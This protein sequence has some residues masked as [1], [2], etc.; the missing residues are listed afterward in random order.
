LAAVG[1]FTRALESVRTAGNHLPHHKALEARIKLLEASYE[2]AT[3]AR[4]KLQGALAQQNWPEVLRIADSFLELAPECRE[5]KQARD[6]AMRRLG[7]RVPQTTYVA[8]TND[9]GDG[10]R[11]RRLRDG[12][13]T[14][15]RFILWVDGVGGFLV[16]TGNVVTLG[17]ATPA[18][19]VEIPILGDLSRQHATIVR[20]GEGYVIRSDRELQVNGRVTG[21]VA[22]RDGDIVRLG[23]TVDLKFSTPCPVSGTARL[24]LVSRHRL[25]LSLAGILLMADNCVIGP[26]RQTHVQ[27]PVGSSQIVIYRQGEGLF[28]RGAGSLEIDGQSHDGR[29]SLRWTSRVIAGDVSLSL[30]P[31]G[32]PLSHV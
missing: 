21:Q 25:H 31:V 23:R 32:S 4:G 29:G 3:A 30:E 9:A 16:C 13:G 12:A 26:T 18:T 7:V 5:V 24:D 28:C 22:L 11:V 14:R 10:L 8:P 1:D 15:N 20:D 6:E 27:V 2:K 19:T 17:Q